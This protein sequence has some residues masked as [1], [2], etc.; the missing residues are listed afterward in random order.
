MSLSSDDEVNIVLD[1]PSQNIENSDFTQIVNNNRFNFNKKCKLNVSLN[2]VINDYINKL[3][4]FYNMGDYLSIDYNLSKI[5]A[6]NI[7][8]I[9]NKTHFIEISYKFRK[10]ILIKNWI[11]KYKNRKNIS[12]REWTD[13]NDRD[14]SLNDFS[15]GQNIFIYKNYKNKT[16]QR[17]TISEMVNI[18]KYS[19]FNNDIFYSYPRPEIPRNPY[20]NNEFN[21]KDLILMYNFILERF[22]EKGKCLPEYIVILK[23]S[24]FDVEILLKKYHGYLCFYC[25]YEYIHSISDEKWTKRFKYFINMYA[26]IKRT[27]CIT[28]ILKIPNYRDI[29]NKVLILS[30]LNTHGSFEYGDAL[31]LY[32]SLQHKHNLLFKP[33]H[34]IEHRRFL[35]SRRGRNIPQRIGTGI[36]E[37]IISSSPIV[38][39]QSNLTIPNTTNDNFLT[40][41]INNV[42]TKMVDDIVINIDSV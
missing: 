23:N 30:E 9:Y 10:I 24:Y 37:P 5:V 8:F 42:I 31:L 25:A 18:F 22:S 14:L 36:V 19:I 13:T 17:F 26:Q 40:E 39:D 7:P 32:N 11:K 35:K 2:V 29:F 27:S 33:D 41:T 3:L 16:I 1:V 28:C 12:K 6:Q 38:F 15:I 4:N 34:H 20:T 21:T